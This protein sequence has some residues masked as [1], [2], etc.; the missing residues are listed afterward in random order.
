MRNFKLFSFI[1][2]ASLLLFSP[3]QAKA[4][5]VAKVIALSQGVVIERAGNQ[6]DVNLEDE[7]HN[8]DTI[9]TDG[10]GRIQLMF[11]DHTLASL[12][13]NTVFTMSDFNF[14][15]NDA[16]FTANIGK[17]FARFVTGKI[18]ESNP[19][20][21]KVITP[22]AT[23]GIRGTTFAVETAN[24]YTTV[25]VENSVK[26]RSVVVNNT[27]I[28][29]GHYA[30]FGPDGRLFTPPTTMNRGHRQVIIEKTSISFLPTI[31][32]PD[33]PNRLP[34]YESDTTLSQ[35]LPFVL[36]SQQSLGTSP[37]SSAG[38]ADS[39]TP[40]TFNPN[41]PNTGIAGLPA[42]TI[43][44]DDAEIKLGVNYTSNGT[45][46]T[47]G[48]LQFDVNLTSGAIS[49]GQAKLPS[50]SLTGAV[51]SDS[52]FKGSGLIQGTQYSISGSQW[53]DNGLEQG[54]ASSWDASGN[55]NIPNNTADGT[56]NFNGGTG[57]YSGNVS[58]I[59]DFE[60]D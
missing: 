44:S 59:I 39:S 6:I 48:E 38:K 22:E 15:Q 31:L 9:I 5:V 51:E 17:G 30:V 42:G 32:N 41:D 23:V 27:V 58:G 21:F 37:E 25:S 36:E 34:A 54:M 28:P 55:I 7:V 11:K 47:D 53:K 35:T 20:A 57:P 56:L 43:L 2:L 1:F 12:S 13:S 10:T 46:F 14:T 52:N 19:E 3:L 60:T 45:P 16:S 49:N 8:N 18:V 40:G 33:D 4:Q 50:G 24:D 29:V 26:T